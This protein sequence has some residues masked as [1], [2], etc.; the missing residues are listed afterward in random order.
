MLKRVD[1]NNPILVAYL[2]TF[3]SSIP[4][5]ILLPR[6]AKKSK[7]LKKVAPASPEQKKNGSKSSK[8]PKKQTKNVEVTIDETH[9][10]EPFVEETQENV[11]IPS[12]T[13]MFRRIKMKSTHKR[14]SLLQKLVCK[15]QITH[16]GVLIR[17][18]PVPVSPGPRNE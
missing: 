13:G 17:D 11:I 7:K 12:K 14:N 3:D 9:V 2:K 10:I 1:P 8:S 4:T 15:P 5:G 16:Q 6:E 18:V